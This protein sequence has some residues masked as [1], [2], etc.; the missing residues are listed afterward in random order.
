MRYI[1]VLNNITEW[2]F[3]LVPHYPMTIEESK[4]IAESLE[5][6]AEKISFEEEVVDGYDVNGFPR[7]KKITR[8]P[9]CKKI[10]KKDCNYCQHCGQKVVF[11]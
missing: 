5:R 4:T 9:S 1:D 3:E 11:K 6:S 8:C 2:D 10:I 7:F